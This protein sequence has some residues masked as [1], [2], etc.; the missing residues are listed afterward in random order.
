MVTRLTTSETARNQTTEHA[1]GATK[2]VTSAATALRSV[3][4]GLAV[5]PHLATHATTAAEKATSLA[6]ATNLAKSAL[7]L[8]TA[9][10]T[11]VVSPAIFPPTA[12]LHVSHAMVVAVVDRNASTVKKVSLMFS[13]HILLSPVCLTLQ[14]V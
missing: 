7:V 12:P 9:S 14:S 6:T 11:T 1:T 13:I 8:T 4:D 5:A 3:A 2:L 10:A